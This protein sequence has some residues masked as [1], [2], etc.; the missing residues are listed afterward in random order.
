[1]IGRAVAEILV[2]AG[3]DTTMTQ[4]QYRHGT[5]VFPKGVN[6]VPYEDRY[7]A[8]A[9]HDAVISAKMCIRDRSITTTMSAAW[10]WAAL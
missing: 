4:R 7:Q 9:E 10:S 1:M 2:R 3:Y 6:I 5:N 8:I